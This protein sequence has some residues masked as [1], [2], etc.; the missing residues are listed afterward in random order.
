M[1]DRMEQG[2]WIVKNGREYSFVAFPSD[3]VTSPC[4]INPPA[5]WQGDI[6]DGIVGMAHSHPF[7]VGEDIST[8][9]EYSEDDVD[10]A[11]QGMPSK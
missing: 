4:G 6:P 7:F 10:P 11:Y 2:G 8:I 1:Q 5:D 9:S 3:W